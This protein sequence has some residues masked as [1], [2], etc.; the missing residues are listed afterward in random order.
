MQ[1]SHGRQGV[2]QKMRFD[3]FAKSRQARIGK[4]LLDRLAVQAF[5]P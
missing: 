1:A 4:L 3:L 5:L 2:E